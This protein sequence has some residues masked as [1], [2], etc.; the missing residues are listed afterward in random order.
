MRS[1]RSSYVLAWRALLW[2]RLMYRR[3]RRTQL[4]SLCASRAWQ[5]TTRVREVRFLLTIDLIDAG[6]SDRTHL[7]VDTS[8]VVAMCLLI[9]TRL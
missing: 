7:E 5:K 6:H 8:A 4:R 3:L 9:L 1:V 2:S